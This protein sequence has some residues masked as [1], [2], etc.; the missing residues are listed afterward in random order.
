MYVH[1]YICSYCF[2]VQVQDN[3]AKDEDVAEMIIKKLEIMNVDVPFA[4]IAQSAMEAKRKNLA[5]LAS[6][7]FS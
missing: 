1:M 7:P 4:E 2:Y 6:L 5:A 3:K